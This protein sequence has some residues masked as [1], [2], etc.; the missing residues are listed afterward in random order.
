MLELSV[1][2]VK[3]RLHRARAD[4]R[5]KL[6]RFLPSG[7]RPS[8]APPSGT[9]PDVVAMFSRYLEHDIGAE[10]CAAMER[11]VAGSSSA[12]PHASP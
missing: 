2:A 8:D 1:D 11:H 3:S 4:V 9:C 10:E 12:A 5:A 6:T 7:E